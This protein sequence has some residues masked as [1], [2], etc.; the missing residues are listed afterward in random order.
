[1][2]LLLDKAGLSGQGW[3]KVLQNWD[4]YAA[5]LSVLASQCEGVSVVACGPSTGPCPA[6]RRP[7]SQGYLVHDT[8]AAGVTD[9]WDPGEF[10]VDLIGSLVSTL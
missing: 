3:R 7:I 10:V 6:S 9:G 1:M 8:T 5:W 2:R 4:N